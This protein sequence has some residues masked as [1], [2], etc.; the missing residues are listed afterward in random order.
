MLG[1]IE[2]ERPSGGPGFDSRGGEDG[3]SIL[4]LIGEAA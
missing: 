4:K 3:K 1:S 2:I